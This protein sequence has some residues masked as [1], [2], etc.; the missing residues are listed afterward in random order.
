[1]FQAEGGALARALQWGIVALVKESK[2]RR[3]GQRAGGRATGDKVGTPAR[4][5]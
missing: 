5:S 2:A 1:M 3:R 4:A